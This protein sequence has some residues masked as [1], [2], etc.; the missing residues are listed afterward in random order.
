MLVSG[1]Q[2][3]DLVVHMHI[4]TF[5]YICIGTWN[6]RFLNQGKLK[7]VKQELERVNIDILGISKLK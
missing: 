6:V 4:Y 3:S 1:I 7:V 2:Q 5:T